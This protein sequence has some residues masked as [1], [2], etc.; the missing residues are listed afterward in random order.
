MIL[1]RCSLGHKELPHAASF[2][3]V[4]K[5]ARFHPRGRASTTIFSTAVAAVLV[6]PDA[7]LT[8]TQL[9]QE[10]L[11]V[12]ILSR[13]S[14][15]F[16]NPRGRASPTAFAKGVDCELSSRLRDLGLL[17]VPRR[18]SF[19]NIL[20]RPASTC[21]TLLKKGAMFLQNLAHD[22]NTGLVL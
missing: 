13:H 20:L 22:D 6:V 3:A 18:P 19:T 17:Y 11:R 15:Y 1:N 10:T 21:A 7:P 14:K 4:C 9:H 5:R 2:T 16:V 12:Q 8:Y